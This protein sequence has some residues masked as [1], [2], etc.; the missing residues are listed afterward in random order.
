MVSEEKILKKKLVDN[1]EAHLLLCDKLSEEMGVPYQQP[2][3]NLSLM[4]LENALRREKE[5]LEVLKKERMAEVGRI[6]E[7]K[8]AFDF[9]CNF[10][11]LDLKKRDEK[12]CQKMEVSKTGKIYF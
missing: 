10:K 11:V 1:S 5:K 6:R 12:V 7:G 3:S 4:K 8:S 9:E 2:D